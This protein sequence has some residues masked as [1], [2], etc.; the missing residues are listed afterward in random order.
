MGGDESCYCVQTLHSK[1]WMQGSVTRFIPS[2]ASSLHGT[3]GHACLAWLSWLSELNSSSFHT[4]LNG[5]A[6]CPRPT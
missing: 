2:A 5:T 1:S 6:N 4:T 3:H